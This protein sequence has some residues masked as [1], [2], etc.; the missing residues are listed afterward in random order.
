MCPTMRKLTTAANPARPQATT[1]NSSIL[2]HSID[3][4]SCL[5]TMLEGVEVRFSLG[6]T[7]GNELAGR[8]VP[9]PTKQVSDLEVSSRRLATARRSS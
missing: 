4:L 3:C 1:I 2:P 9:N 6:H 5:L 7:K 8:A